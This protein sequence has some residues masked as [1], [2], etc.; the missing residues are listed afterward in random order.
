M[1]KA[2][3]AK[4][5]HQETG[6]SE[7]EAARVLEWILGFLKSTLQAGEPII[8]N[9]FGKFTVRHKRPRLGRNPRTG[10]AVMI[11]AH[12]VVTF[13]PSLDFKMEMESLSEEGWNA[14]A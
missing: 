4:R 3:I 11:S 13:H 9:G 12:R 2:E 7:K 6:I 8:I 14:M 10:E 5:M 1:G